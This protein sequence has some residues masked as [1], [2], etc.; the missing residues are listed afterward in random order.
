VGGL[1][2]VQCSIGPGGGVVKCL[3]FGLKTLLF[4]HRGSAVLWV[5]MYG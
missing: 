2:L 1:L 4:G 5:A 3:L